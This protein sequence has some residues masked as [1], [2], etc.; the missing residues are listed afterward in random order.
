[1]GVRIGG[2][3]KNTQLKRVKFTVKDDV[4]VPEGYTSLKELT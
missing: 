4:I 2:V 3:D 1:M